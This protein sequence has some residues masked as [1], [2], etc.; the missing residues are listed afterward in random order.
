MR[1]SVG[2][3]PFRFYS[4]YGHRKRTP[5]NPTLVTFAV[6]LTLCIAG[7]V[8]VQVEGHSVPTTI[9]ATLAVLVVSIKILATRHWVNSS[10]YW[11]GEH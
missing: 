9:G 2:L 10:N 11:V 1:M 8:F 7:I 4:G 5:L 6:W 3:G